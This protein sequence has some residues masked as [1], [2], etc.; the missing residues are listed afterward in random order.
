LKGWIWKWIKKFEDTEFARKE[1]L[2]ISS[3]LSFEFQSF[4]LKFRAFI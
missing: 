4:D 1:E 2:E 3:E